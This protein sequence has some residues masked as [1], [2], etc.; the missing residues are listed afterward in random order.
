LPVRVF[1]L[2]LVLILVLGGVLRFSG[3]E[4][5]IPTAPVWRNYFQDEAWALSVVLQM[6]PGR[7]DFNPHNFV[8]PSFHFYTMLGALETASLFGYLHDFNLPIK[9]NPLGWGESEGKL[10]EYRKMFKVGRILTM[11]EG[12]LTVLLVFLIGARLYNPLLGLVAAALMAVIPAHIYH[13]HF[14]V[15]DQTP[16]F[17]LTLAFWW[18]TTP[19]FKRQRY[20]WFAIAGFFIGLAIGVK[21][22]NL[23]LM[24]TFYVKQWYEMKREANFHKYELRTLRPIIFS[25]SSLIVL[26]TAVL[27]FII[28][29]P[30]ALLSPHEFLIGDATGWGGIFGARGLFYYMNFPFSVTRPFMVGTWLMLPLSFFVL[31]MTGFVWHFI[32][33]KEADI[34]ILSFVAIYYLTLIYH[35]SPH[36]RH[37]IPLAPFLSISAALVALNIPHVLKKIPF[38]VANF[39]SILL[40]ALPIIQTLDFAFAQVRRMDSQDT[41]DEC[42]EWVEK[43]IAPS[44]TI[45]LASFFPWAY[46]PAIDLTHQ[47]LMN[48]GYNYDR[49]TYL[50][51][52]YFL[53]TQQE[54][55]DRR[56]NE[57]SKFVTDRF[58]K[59]LFEQ[60]SYKIKR[61]FKHPYRGL[62]F[63]YHP[64]FPSFEWDVVSPEIR[65]YR[66]P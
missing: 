10:R 62:V 42:R 40:V 63:N 51:P 34:M 7:G 44:D 24:L 43:N 55:K 25:K 19:V 39:V 66:R 49:L 54:F 52:K 11:L 33:R 17:W 48:V 35:A 21:Y 37:Y 36:S 57:E 20:W 45:G 23:F 2:P 3:L 56:S 8:N 12:T 29:T 50:R 1:I 9:V 13:S 32:R 64:N 16:V 26:A 18:L 60:Q 28:T 30:Y 38:R 6:E 4:W 46:T 47:N 31:A 15:Y 27:T 5:G 14:L 65:I 61:V 59:L 58:L 41:R 53:I 22:T